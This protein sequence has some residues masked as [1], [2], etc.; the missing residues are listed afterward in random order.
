MKIAIG[1]DH[2]GYELKENLRQYLAE[3]GHQVTDFGAFGSQSCDY[4]LIAEKVS[5]EVAR[6]RF[7]YGVLVCTTGIGM[8]MAANK[9]KGIRAALCWNEKLAYYARG[10]NNANIISLPGKFLGRKKAE[11]IIDTWLHTRFFGGRHRRR[12]KQIMRL[13]KR[14]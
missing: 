1:A 2:G 5:R 14:F 7:R 12:V 13:E 10:H 11:E 6:G 3:K 9:V 8:S 4:P